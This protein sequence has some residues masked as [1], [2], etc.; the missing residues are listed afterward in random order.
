MRKQLMRCKHGRTYVRGCADCH[1]PPVTDT[2]RAITPGR[3]TRKSLSVRRVSGKPLPI[4]MQCHPVALTRTSLNPECM[5]YDTY[6]GLALQL[7][8]DHGTLWFLSGHGLNKTSGRFS[9]EWYSEV[10]G[11]TDDPIYA[12]AWRS[13]ADSYGIKV[14]ILEV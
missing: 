5:T 11:Y 9:L 7:Q 8:R 1:P 4:N 10:M 2:G 12:K 6:A 3:V 13:A 14:E